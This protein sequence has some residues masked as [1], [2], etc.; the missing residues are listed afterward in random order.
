MGTEMEGMGDMDMGTAQGIWT[1][2][3]QRLPLLLRMEERGGITGMGIGRGGGMLVKG[4][5][6]MRMGM[7]MGMGLLLRLMG[8]RMGTAIIEVLLLLMTKLFLLVIGWTRQEMI[9]S[10][11]RRREC[12]GVGEAR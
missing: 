9:T 7:E 1:S 5:T 4:A 8:M 2:T 12:R 10:G 6:G 3:S 11:V